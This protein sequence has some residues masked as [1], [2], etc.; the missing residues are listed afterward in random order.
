MLPKKVAT[1]QNQ[2][3]VERAIHIQIPILPRLESSSTRLNIE[4]K[5]TNTFALAKLVKAPFR[6]SLKLG[7]VIKGI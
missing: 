5:K 2:I 6:K 4:L 3:N 7:G 1:I